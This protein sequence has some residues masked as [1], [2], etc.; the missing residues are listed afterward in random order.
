M[1]D[2]NEA[3]QRGDFMLEDFVASYAQE[4]NYEFLGNA[5]PMEVGLRRQPPALPK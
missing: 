4:Q 5:T 3:T 1:G 2:R